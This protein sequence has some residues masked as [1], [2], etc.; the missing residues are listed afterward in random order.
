MAMSDVNTRTTAIM[1]T[2]ALRGSV[3]RSEVV[4]EMAH[5]QWQ[6]ELVAVLLWQRQDE[7][8]AVLLWQRQRRRLLQECED[9]GETRIGIC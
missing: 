1:H 9:L 2:R 3:G 4:A 7:L 6:D 8:V 5:E